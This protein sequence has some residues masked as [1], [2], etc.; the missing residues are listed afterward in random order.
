MTTSNWR[1]GATDA[2]VCGFLFSTT[3]HNAFLQHTNSQIHQRL[4]GHKS[5]TARSDGIMPKV[6][7][8]EQIIQRQRINVRPTYLT[9]ERG[10]Y[11]H[12]QEIKR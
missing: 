8:V 10:F 4:Q 7:P 9:T 5:N 2:C 6:P 1:K 12:Q 11:P 3:N